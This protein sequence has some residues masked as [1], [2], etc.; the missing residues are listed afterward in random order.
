MPQER[1]IDIDNN[2]QLEI[3]KF[4]YKKFSNNEI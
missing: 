2:F 3:A 4:L 1:S